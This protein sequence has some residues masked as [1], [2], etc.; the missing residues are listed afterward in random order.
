MVHME[1][2]ENMLTEP[3]NINNLLEPSANDTDERRMFVSIPREDEREKTAT[4]RCSAEVKE[5]QNVSTNQ[6]LNASMKCLK[7]PLTGFLVYN[8]EY[9]YEKENH[10]SVAKMEE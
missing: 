2:T 9:I 6:A 4:H 5:L 3:N 1:F 8:D 7:R 10:S